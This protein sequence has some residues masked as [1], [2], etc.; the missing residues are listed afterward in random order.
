MEDGEWGRG[1][2]TL[3]RVARECLRGEVTLEKGSERGS[4]SGGY[5]G[6]KTFPAAS[7]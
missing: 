6:G 4:Q 2:A 7:W 3:N 5:L 1:A